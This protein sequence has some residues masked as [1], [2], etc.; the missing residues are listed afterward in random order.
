M[1]AVMVL[2]TEPLYIYQSNKWMNNVLSFQILDSQS[3]TKRE[4]TMAQRKADRK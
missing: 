1:Y 3:K 2:V 4:T